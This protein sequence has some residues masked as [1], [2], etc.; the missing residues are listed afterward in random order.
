MG[1]IT[2]QLYSLILASAIITMLLT[3][4]SLNLASWSYARIT[5]SPLGRR[6]ASKEA[7]LLPS[8]P[9]EEPNRV[10]VAGYGRTGQN[11]A[12]GLQDAGIPYIVIDIDPKR[13]AEARSSGRP[14][15]YGDASN[16]HVLSQINLG[17]AKVLVVTF[18]DPMAVTTAVKAAL[19]INP[20][21]K[22]IARAHRARE[23]D[24]LKSMG[25]VEVISP[26]YEASLEF[27]R[28]ILAASGR[29]KAGNRQTLPIVEKDKDF[30]EFNRDQEV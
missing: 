7:P 2:D 6:L 28:R 10:V 15:I 8:K 23:A 11:I 21:L 16:H 12:Q 18:P 4:L 1:A 19:E 25:A 17:K 5:A 26:E 20:K 24:L 22:V 14:R 13:I 29:K 30:V 9:P 3:P 27:M